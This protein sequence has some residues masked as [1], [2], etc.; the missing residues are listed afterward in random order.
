MRGWWRFR[1]LSCGMGSDPA[2]RSEERADAECDTTARQRRV[3]AQQ[4]GVRAHFAVGQVAAIQEHLVAV[5]RVAVPTVGQVG[6]DQGVAVARFL[7]LRDVLLAAV[8]H[9]TDR[10]APAILRPAQVG[11]DAGR[12]DTRQVAGIG[13][14]H[15]VV[16]VVVAMR[17]GDV[18]VAAAAAIQLGLHVV[19]EQAQV[20]VT[21]ATLEQVHQCFGLGT[22]EHRVL[23]G[24]RTNRQA[25]GDAGVGQVDEVLE[26]GLVDRCGE[27]QAVTVGVDAKLDTLAALGLQVGITDFQRTGGDVSTASLSFQMPAADR[28]VAPEVRR[29]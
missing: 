12:S 5:A 29:R 14:F 1:A 13:Q 7:V 4:R 21:G 26:L 25:L 15:R 22:A 19:A 17:H 3:V 24:P 20:P 11:A 27:V 16:V 2:A 28:L 8:T 10:G 6:I 9:R 23:L 18:Q